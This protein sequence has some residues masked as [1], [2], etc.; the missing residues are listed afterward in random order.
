M[1]NPKWIGLIVFVWITLTF[2]GATFEG[3]STTT[4][5]WEGD[6]QETQLEYL[7][8]VKN[9]VAQTSETGE[10]SF[11]LFNTEYFK[12]V[13]QMI[14]WDFT[15]LQGEGYEIIR[16]IVFIPIS[17]VISYGLLYAFIQLAQGFIPFT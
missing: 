17:A 4:G 10:V 5:D 7:M 2:L 3:H 14:T 12:T 1:L 11:V 8:N 9:V 6:T 16:W 15:F 13:W